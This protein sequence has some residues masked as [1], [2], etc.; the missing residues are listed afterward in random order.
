MSEF[1]EL[2]QTNTRHMFGG[3]GL[4]YDGIMFGLVA[5]DQFYLKVDDTNRAD[6]EAL[7]LTTFEYNKN[8]KVMTMSY[9][10]APEEIY[11]YPEV[12]AVWARKS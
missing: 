8:G 6:F 10:H 3:H 5:D 11:D 9:C 7:G 12:A 2:G 4:Y 1:A